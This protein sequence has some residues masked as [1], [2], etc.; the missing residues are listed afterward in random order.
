MNTC[1]QNQLNLNYFEFISHVM[2]YYQNIGIILVSGSIIFLFLIKNQKCICIK[3]LT[4]ISAVLS[5]AYLIF[6]FIVYNFIKN[7]HEDLFMG[8]NVDY[9]K[10]DRLMVF[11]GWI[12]ILT[13]IFLAIPTLI[14]V[15][16]KKDDA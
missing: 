4:S 5:V 15:F 14:F 2:T 7:S 13:V 12:G 3:I 6:G 1:F 16:G 9:I 8:V 10:V 11:Q